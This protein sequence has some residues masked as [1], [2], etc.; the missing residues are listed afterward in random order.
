[1]NASQI[2]NHVAKQIEKDRVGG[3]SIDELWMGIDPD[4]RG[5]VAFALVDLIGEGRVEITSKRFFDNVG[6]AETVTSYRKIWK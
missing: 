4:Q 2:K 5:Q 6:N 3:Y 1:M